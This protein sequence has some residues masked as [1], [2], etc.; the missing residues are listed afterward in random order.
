M[1]G[2]IQHHQA[3][4]I[5]GRNEPGAVLTEM[6]GKK[7]DSTTEIPNSVCGLKILGLSSRVQGPPPATAEPIGAGEWPN[8]GVC[9]EP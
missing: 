3:A 9:Q 8:G 6:D 2:G 4:Q 7:Y 5:I 1:A